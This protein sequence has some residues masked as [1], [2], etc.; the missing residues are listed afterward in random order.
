[1]IACSTT[2]T[3][4]IRNT[5]TK[6]MNDYENSHDVLANI[7]LDRNA[8]ALN[9]KGGEDAKKDWIKVF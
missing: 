3:L 5:A 9:F 6:L 8:L 2:I 4:A 1:M 7:S